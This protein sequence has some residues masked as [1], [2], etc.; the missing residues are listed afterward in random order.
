M[1][2]ALISTEQLIQKFLDKQGFDVF[3]PYFDNVKRYD[4]EADLKRE[5]EFLTTALTVLNNFLEI[6]C[7]KSKVFMKDVNKFVD[8]LKNITDSSSGNNESLSIA[9]S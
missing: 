3:K 8:M 7:D 9:S 5:I 1:A 4:T 2:S 6:K